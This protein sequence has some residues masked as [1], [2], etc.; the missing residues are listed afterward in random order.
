MAISYFGFTK[1]LSNKQ[2]SVCFLHLLHIFKRISE[3]I[4]LEANNMNPDQ[5][6]PL[7]PYC[8]QF[9]LP[10]TISRQARQ[11]TKVVTSWLRI[12]QICV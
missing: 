8:L 9:R 11:A 12:S 2:T 4:L 1:P 7:D 6:A 5:T 3:K 10:K